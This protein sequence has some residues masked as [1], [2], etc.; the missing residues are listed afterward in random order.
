M[1]YI[2]AMNG[3]E[4]ASALDITR[5]AVSGSLKRGMCK[6]YKYTRTTLPE[7]STLECSIFLLK[8]LDMIGTLDFTMN[9]IKRFNKL[10]PYNIRKEIEM[11]TIEKKKYGY[12]TILEKINNI[13]EI[14]KWRS[15]GEY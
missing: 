13:F 8:W 1:A 14:L 7:L 5:Q 9:E 6:C 11:D 4:I 10:F 15:D 12:R 2:K 3:E